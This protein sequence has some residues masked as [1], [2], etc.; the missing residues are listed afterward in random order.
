MTTDRVSQGWASLP[1]LLAAAVLFAA[2]MTAGGLLSPDPVRQ[3][4]PENA[5]DVGAAQA[6]LA[7]ILGDEAPHPVDTDA[8][9]AVRERLLAEIRAL[10]FAPD[11]RD[12]FACRS[13]PDGET[14][15]ARVRNIV[16]S[17][18]PATGPAILAAA[19]YDSVPAGPGASD[20]GIGIAAWLE[21]ARHLR[22]APL[23]RRVIFLFSDG[24]EMGLLGA[25][26]FAVDD[27]LYESVEAIVNLEARGSSGPA[28]FFETNRPNA[29]AVS[30]YF[31]SVSR[32]TA[33]SIAADV[34]RLLPNSTDVTALTRPD[35][36]VVNIAIVDGFEDYHTPSDSLAEQDPA[37]LQHMGDQALAATLSFAGHGDR[38]S[39]ENLAFTDVMARGFV[40]LPENA[41]R[42]ALG[43]CAALALLVFWRAGRERR[44]LALATPLIVLAG[45]GLLAFAAGWVL[46]ALHPRFWFAHPELTR[47]W[48]LLLALS[49]ILAAA[50]WFARGAPKA[51]LAASGAL[52]Y[53]LVGFAGSLILPG[54]SI[55]F[56]P[57]AL[58]FAL[59]GIVALIWRPALWIGLAAAAIVA[60]VLWAP[61]L[62]FLEISL[63]YDAPFVHAILF[64]LMLTPWLGLLS[65]LGASRWTAG[66]AGAAT[67]AAIAA[68]AFAPP[69]SE[70]RPRGLNVVHFQNLTSGEARFA[71]GG[72]KIPLPA[73]LAGAAA[74][75]PE[76]LFPGDETPFWTTLAPPVAVS[77]PDAVVT[78][79][80]RAV[81]QTRVR[82]QVH[83]NGAYRTSVRIP[84]AALPQEI[85]VNGVASETQGDTG[86]A[87]V[88]VGCSGRSCAEF[89]IE[90][91]LGGDPAAGDWYVS[92][93]Y[94]GASPA[95]AALVAARPATAH[96]IQMGDG[97]STLREVA[98]QASESDQPTQAP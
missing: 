42:I 69:F 65:A 72:A 86:D 58:L 28:W 96:P 94:L 27:P 36:D 70:A 11:V 22:T 93:F 12:D 15:C 61:L 2:A 85:T 97:V 31:S 80:V 54:L 7:R 38:G 76:L 4:S 18:G 20:D 83:A 29:D 59:G 16:F 78:A 3:S 56:L 53:A 81:G 66:L 74:F 46:N 63:G 39:T 98:L 40:S 5:F 32:P 82:L 23:Q 44:W 50:G 90:V 60:V 62:T 95:A 87:Y 73:P 64:S 68:A 14:E 37:S 77:G 41:S 51:T 55:L 34:Y 8:E 48:T 1:A 24:E 57:S 26:A 67:V 88:L 30:T 10:G 71:V 47:A 91:T 52:T 35:V 43:L 92:G 19:H 84:R 75:S 6:R 17:A 45:A 49:M 79:I 33:N 9:D 13:F 25:Q 89:E 21:A